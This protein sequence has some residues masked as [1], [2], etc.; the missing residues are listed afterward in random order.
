VRIEG[1]TDDQGPTHVNQRLSQERA[2]AVRSYLIGK[3]VSPARLRSV[4]FGPTRP[5]QP[6]ES[7]TARAANRRVE[8]HLES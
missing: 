7:D 2:D 8:F 4:G 1:H 3:G 5:L 6:G